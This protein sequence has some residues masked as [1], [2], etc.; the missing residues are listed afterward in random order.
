M[1]HQ[2]NIELAVAYEISSNR[3]KNRLEAKLYFFIFFLH[4]FSCTLT[5]W[6]NNLQNT[7][8]CVGFFLMAAK[9][10]KQH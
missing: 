2:V 5:T 9:P 7:L 10:L 6:Y 3:I 1:L 4:S 8:V